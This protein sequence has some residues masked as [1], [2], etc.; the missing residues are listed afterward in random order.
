MAGKHATRSLC[1]THRLKNFWRRVGILRLKWVGWVCSLSKVLDNLWNAG[2]HQV[3]DAGFRFDGGITWSNSSLIARLPA[4]GVKVAFARC[5]SYTRWQALP[6]TV[7]VAL[8]RR[9]NAIS[10]IDVGAF[11]KASVDAVQCTLNRNMTIL[12]V[13]ITICATEFREAEASAIVTPPVPSA[14]PRASF[15]RAVKATKPRF[16]P[17]RAVDTWP[18]VRAIADALWN[19]AIVSTPVW[20]AGAGPVV[21][22]SM[23]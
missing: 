22:I 10:A 7:H 4:N 19:R 8:T 20:N 15:Q 3:G 11:A 17:A 12:C 1:F 16:A 14:V 13:N 9:T 6:C 18:I 5:A 2:G 23:A 21:A